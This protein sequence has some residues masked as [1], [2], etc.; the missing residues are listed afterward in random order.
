MVFHSYKGGTGKTT[1]SINLAGLLANQGHKVCLLDCDLYAPSFYTY[2][3]NIEALPNKFINDY[4]YNKCDLNEILIDISNSLKIPN[5]GKLEIAFSNSDKNEIVKFDSLDF[6]E[7]KNT[8]QRIIQAKNKI[9]L[10]HKVD[11]LI[12]D[13]SPG[14]KFWPINC[15]SISDIIFLVLKMGELDIEGTKM[16]A[17]EILVP[18]SDIGT[19]SFLLLNR[20][21]GYCVPIGNLKNI[22]NCDDNHLPEIIKYKIKDVTS[23]NELA[24]IIFQETGLKVIGNIPCY[25]DIQFSKREY[26]TSIYYQQHPFTKRM[27]DLAYKIKEWHSLS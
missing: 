25:C 15:L 9:L 17:K 8:L 4:L 21:A 26:F 1:L 20:V 11:Y 24:N 18:F 10:E 6:Q 19:Y 27:I 13:T 5:N 3:Q 16:M 22:H 2:F 12:I 7:R 14:I 23:D